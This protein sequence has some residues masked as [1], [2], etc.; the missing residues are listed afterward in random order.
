MEKARLRRALRKAFKSSVQG[1]STDITLVFR[2]TKPLLPEWGGGE[3]LKG[4][5]GS[6]AGILLLPRE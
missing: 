4:E 6:N 2:V 1:S 5:I 3:I